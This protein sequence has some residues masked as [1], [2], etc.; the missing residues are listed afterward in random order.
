MRSNSAA[1]SAATISP[2]KATPASIGRAIREEATAIGRLLAWLPFWV[3]LVVVL[4]GLVLAYQVPHVYQ[5]D[6][7]T[8]RDQAY[9]RNFHT[10]LDDNGRAYRWS[11]VYG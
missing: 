8:P 4:G 1:G 3:A 7:G 2:A 9:M 10:R 11:D 6:V 5:V